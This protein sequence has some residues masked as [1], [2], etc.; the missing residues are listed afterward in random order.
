MI[1]ILKKCIAAILLFAA[2][3]LTVTNSFAQKLDRKQIIRD[4]LI[5]VFKDHDTSGTF[6]LYNAT[7]GTMTL[8]NAPRAITPMIPASTFKIINS[9][10]ALETGVIADENEIIPY[11]GGKTFVKS[12]AKDM[13]IRDAIKI[14]N[15]P[16]YQ[17][18]AR[19]IGVDRYQKWLA[20]L[21][22]GNGLIGDDV[23]RF[24]LKGPLTT[25]A[26]EQAA[27]LAQLAMGA[28]P[29]SIAHQQTVANITNVERKGN[30]ILHGKT[31]WTTTPDPDIGW[32]V[33]WVSDG[34]NI[35]SF[36]L[37]MDINVRKDTNNRTKIAIELL[38]QLDIY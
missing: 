37:N 27:F 4:D 29:A 17:E 13:S 22:Y 14:S 25:S 36:A 15:V 28:L 8:I 18:L 6:A 9:L 30:K 16:I 5:S 1:P 35:T 32:F 20:K 10:I 38:R 12:W 19:R 34:D 7:S 24:W 2:M 23:E 31:G 21:N 33:G 3:A 11:G 26:V